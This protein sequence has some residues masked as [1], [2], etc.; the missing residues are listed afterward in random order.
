MNAKIYTRSDILKSYNAGMKTGL[1]LSIDTVMD[2]VT[3]KLQD[4]HEWEPDDL[5]KL[6][7]EINDEFNAVC[8][9]RVSLDE[10]AEAK[11]EEIG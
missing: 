3:L 1:R 8:E 9:N 6:E 7:K 4:K 5:K 2:I 10:I 11:R